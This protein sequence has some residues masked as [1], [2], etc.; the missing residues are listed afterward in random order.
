MSRH[1]DV[2]YHQNYQ[3]VDFKGHSGVMKLAYR[4]QYKHDN[5][6]THKTSGKGLG[7][8]DI[9]I[10]TFKYFFQILPEQTK[11]NRPFS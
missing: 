8:I 5:Y 9:V 11:F 2:L 7:M 1:I 10:E 3:D 4:H 6:S